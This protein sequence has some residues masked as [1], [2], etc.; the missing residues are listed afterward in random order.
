MKNIF[1]KEVPSINCLARYNKPM[2]FDNLFS[3]VFM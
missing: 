3:T 1:F 2:F